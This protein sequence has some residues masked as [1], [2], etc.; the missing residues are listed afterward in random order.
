VRAGTS[1]GASR[2]GEKREGERCKRQR[3]CSLYT[4]DKFYSSPSLTKHL[5]G[6]LGGVCITSGMGNGKVEKRGRGPP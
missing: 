3:D 5:P 4:V 2:D 6:V 1:I